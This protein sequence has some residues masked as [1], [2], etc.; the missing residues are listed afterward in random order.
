M[1][2]ASSP[3]TSRKS[4]HDKVNT[5]SRYRFVLKSIF[6][7]LNENINYNGGYEFRLILQGEIHRGHRYHRR[8]SLYNNVLHQQI[9]ALEQI[10][11]NQRHLYSQEGSP[12]SNK[13]PTEMWPMKNNNTDNS[14]HN[15]NLV[16]S[17]QPWKE[18]DARF[19]T[20]RV[21][22]TLFHAVM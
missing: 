10:K 21:S 15:Y 22:N 5:F 13:R 9:Q 17:Y 8:V 19:L 1:S 4:F 14:S 12:T 3:G 7:N 16:D 6:S 11:N 18:E 2:N 20:P